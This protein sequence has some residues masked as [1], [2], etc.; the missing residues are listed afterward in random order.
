MG[1]WE[2]T[3]SFGRKSAKSTNRLPE[4]LGA[5][6]DT[7]HR[8]SK[9][10]G[11]PYRSCRSV[12]HELTPQHAQRRVHICRHLNGR[13]VRCDEKWIYFR[14]PDASEVSR[15]TSTCQS[16][17]LKNRFGPKVMLYVWWDFEGA[18]YWKFVPNGHA[19]H[20]DLHSQQ[21]ER[22]REI[23]RWRYL[24]LLTEIELSCSGT[25]RDPTNNHDK[26][27]GIGRIW[28][29]LHPVYTAFAP[30]DYHLFRS[31]AHFLRGRNFEN[32]EAVEVGSHRILRF[33][34]QRLVPSRDN[35]HRWKKVQPWAARQVN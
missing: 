27:S 7:I 28:T 31:L 35:K 32:I 12:P 16:Y 9:T 1:Y 21:L 3:Q 34:N 10:L 23:L 11:K 19:V 5:P 14:N 8:Q 13:T 26:N 25:M 20:A 2:Y 18:I 30:S 22:V 17:R 4:E 29:V 24:A 33:K 15:S 6:K